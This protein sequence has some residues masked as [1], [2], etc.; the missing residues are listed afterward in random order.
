MVVL[1]GRGGHYE[2][3]S[4]VHNWIVLVIVTVRSKSP[5]NLLEMLAG[6][7]DELARSNWL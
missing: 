2:L 6:G 7:D 1:G 4:S 3:G 5:F